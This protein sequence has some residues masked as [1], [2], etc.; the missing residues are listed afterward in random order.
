[1]QRKLSIRIIV[2][3]AALSLCVG[4]CSAF[5]PVRSAASADSSPLF[6]APT[7]AVRATPRPTL[8]PTNAADSQPANC[9]DILSF[10]QD[11]SIPDGSIV[12]PGSALDKQWQVKNSG[13]CNWNDTY[14][15]Q[16]IDGDSLGTAS[17]QSIVPAR[18]GTEATIRILFTAPDVPGK[19]ASTW[20]AFDPNGNAFG[21]PFT[22]VINVSNQ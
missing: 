7:S 2:I 13:T 6:I 14:T 12:K 1:M 9:T 8:R 15:V 4:G 22:I 20:K 17:P 19:Y 21:D 16:K 10:E 18:G 11:L 3:T 5:R